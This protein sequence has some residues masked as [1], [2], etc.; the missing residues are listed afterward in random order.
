M[1]CGMKTSPRRGC[2]RISRGELMRRGVDVLHVRA[3]HLH[4]DRRRQPQV[5]HRVHHAARLEVGAQLRHFVLRSRCLHPRH[6]L[7]AARLVFLL[8]SS[9]A[10]RPC[11]SPS[12]SCRSTRTRRR[13]D[14]RDDQ[15]EVL[16]RHHLADQRFHFGDFA[17]GH[18]DARAGRGLQVDHELPRVGAREEREPEQRET[19]RGWPR[20]PR[21]TA[22]SATA[23]RRSTTAHR[24]GRTPSGTIR[25]GR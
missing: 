2:C 24:S 9:P 19:A 8:Q 16:R 20:T 4:V 1:S 10:R 6:V 17:L 11:A 12:W 23:G 7:V 15:P 18:L 3:R 13:P 25:S 14:I 22:P 5:Q 21:R